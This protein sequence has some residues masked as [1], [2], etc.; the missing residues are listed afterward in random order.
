MPLLAMIDCRSNCGLCFAICTLPFGE[1]ELCCD[2]S[3][4]DV[5]I[6]DE[7]KLCAAQQS[8]NR[9]LWIDLNHGCEPAWAKTTGL[10]HAS[11]VAPQVAPAGA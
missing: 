7:F 5:P 8:V 10:R 2:L 11:G 6:D 1:C 3:V 4:H 9:A